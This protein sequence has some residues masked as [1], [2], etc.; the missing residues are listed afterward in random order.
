MPTGALTANFDVAQLVLYAFWAFFAGLVYY[1]MLENH[2]EG[3][4]M[5]SGRENGPVIGGW[6]VP[7]SK[8]YK[9]RHGPDMQAPNFDRVDG[10]YSFEPANP[11]AGG[12][13]QPKGDPLLAGV[14]PGGWAMR[15]DEPDLTL[16]G[17]P[18]IVPLRAATGYNVSPKGVDPRGLPAFGHD[19]ESAGEVCD[20]WVDQSESIFRYIEVA[21]K[22][23]GERVLIPMNFA[24][25]NKS[26]VHVNALMAE[27]FANVP[28]TRLPDQI[29]MLEEEKIMG[30]FGAGLFY[31]HPNRT[32]PLL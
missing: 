10:D 4:P 2:R 22:G 31:A 30:Y 32:E 6:P 16:E 3:Y 15:A 24:R 26:G 11:W 7:S 5:D 23:T 25:I 20:M 8:T 18:K 14:G 13:I 12:T 28:K 9:M 17:G 29:T 21:I 19:K 27:H 1:L